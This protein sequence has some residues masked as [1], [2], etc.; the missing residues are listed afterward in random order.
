MHDACQPGGHGLVGARGLRDDL[1]GAVRGPRHSTQRDLETALMIHFRDKSRGPLGD[2]RSA[3]RWLGALPGNDP[4]LAQREVLAALDKLTERTARRTPA[5]LHAVFAV[6]AHMDGL[7]RNITAQYVEHAGRSS[8]IESQLWQALFDAAQGFEACYAAFAR[9]IKDPE[10]HDKWQALVPELLARQIG[11]LGLDAKIRLFRY[12]RWIPAKWAELNALFARA[13]SIHVE[14]QPLLLE[15]ASGPT[16]IEH[17]Y[18]TV[19]LLQL[20]DPGN[21][22]PRQIEWVA[23]QLDD[24]CRPLRLT[25]A[26][27]SATTFYID[28]AGSTGLRRRTLGPLEGRVLFVDTLP[29]H[30]SLLENRAA[31]EQAVRS[32]PLSRRTP[33]QREQLELFVKLASR[34]DP[35]S[36]PIARRGE[37]VA[38]SGAV[39]AIIGFD[40]ISGFLRDDAPLVVSDYDTRR[41][42]ASTMDLAVFGRTRAEPDHRIENARRR[43]AAFAAPGGVWELKDTSASGFRLHAPMSVATE[44]RLSMLVAID[45]C[46]QN[47]WVMGIVR[48]MRR[49]STAHAEI[50]LQLIANALAGA[51]L[52]EQRKQH[53]TDYTVDREPTTIGARRFRGLFLSFSRRA[54]EPTVQSLIVPHADYQPGKRYTLHTPGSARLIRFGRLLEQHT[55]WVWTVIEPI[56]PTAA[57]PDTAPA[58]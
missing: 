9:E 29:M 4:L 1:G 46:G 34:I 33:Q 3:R 10:R 51:E 41:N 58:A 16:T 40:N 20:A 23:S 49:L 44:I 26:P 47:A 15:P 25:V 42:Y 53:D 38:A 50:G 43:L 37:R 12:E 27:R 11:H 6:D 55:D 13:F 35:E 30:A 48:R 32:D 45:R 39:D 19:L 54:G 21:L 18:L 22:T 17:R 57:A 5:G 24:W 7:V 2:A 8:R 14:R 28:L 52:V 31:L 36:R 56:E